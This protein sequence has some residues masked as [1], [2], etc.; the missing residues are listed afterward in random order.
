LEDC[1][2]IEKGG[3]D[4][5]SRWAADADDTDTATSGRRREGDDGV[6]GGKHLRESATSTR[7]AKAQS[8]S[9]LRQKS[10]L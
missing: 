7:D 6:V 10:L 8:V 4:T 3:R 5:R 9:V 2:E 1:V